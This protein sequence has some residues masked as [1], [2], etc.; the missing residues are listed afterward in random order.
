MSATLEANFCI[1]APEVVLALHGTPEIV[2]THQGAQFTGC[3]WIATVEAACARVSMDA[4]GV[5]RDDIFVE[6]LWRS[7]KYEEVY[8]HDYADGVE[9]KRL[10]NAGRGVP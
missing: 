7:V 10:Q 8:L 4:K 1:D 9:A 5:Y 3:D 6:Q 2:N